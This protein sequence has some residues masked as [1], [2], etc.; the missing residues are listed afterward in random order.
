MHLEK[1]I[2]MLDLKIAVLTANIK[3]VIMKRYKTFLSISMVVFVVAGMMSG[4]TSQREST[5]SPSPTAGAQTQQSTEETTHKLITDE[6]VT[7]RLVRS[8][9]PAQP[10]TLDNIGIQ[11]IYKRTGVK[12]EVETIPGADFAEKQKVMV[13]T[14][15]MPD[16][17]YDTYNVSDFAGS[18][19]FACISDYFDI[20]P[21]F[22]ALWDA[23]PDL[24]KIN[25]DGKLYQVPV[26]G[27]YIY[28]FGRSPMI[29]EDLLVETGLEAPKTFD[30]LYTVLKAIKEKHPDTYPLA[31][32]NGTE[33]LFTCFGYSFGSGNN[34]YFDPL[35]GGGKYLYAQA[36]DEF[37]PML[38]YLHKL[39][40][41]GLLDPDYAVASSSQWQEKLAAGRSSFFFDNPSFAVNFNKALAETDTN[42]LFGPME[43][44][45]TSSGL[46][47]G[48][49]YSKD[50]M[51]ATTVNAKSE[52]LE[53]ALKLIDYLYSDEGCDLT[54][55]GI[56]GQQYDKSGDNYTLKEEVI[57]QY[58]TQTD[59]LR[60]FY[61]S[62]GGG[63]L[64]LARYIDERAQDAFFDE[65]TKSW[66][67]TWST[68]NF[69]DEMVIDPPFT[70]EEAETLK[71][72]RTNITTILAAEYD[73][74]II[75]TRPTSEWKQVQQQ[76]SEAGALEM[77]QIYADALARVK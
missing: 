9:N 51:G 11:E 32:R 77:E 74:F 62:I 40:A 18:G 15:N 50:D 36:H 35:A 43:I 47:R 37:I 39:Y 10:M 20:M 73:N 16:I 71:D 53:V 63:K 48:L 69:M 44:P 8:D 34:M 61:G 1:S 68:W 54:N 33:N 24:K 25:I 41:E 70:A 52:N 21:N 6:D 60:A 75:G 42:A 7:I 59:P 65:Q 28:R 58:M 46:Q 14:G 3:E 67:N 27:R 31:N 26:L 45:A 4:C 13:S 38:E 17:L 22:K 64:G 30:D 19:V 12:L 49:F 29:R 55:F 56:E 2:E 72:M 23:N 5:S 76:I 66:Y 57:N